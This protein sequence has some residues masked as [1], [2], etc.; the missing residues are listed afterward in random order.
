MGDFYEANKILSMKTLAGETPDICFVTG[1]K[2]AGKTTDFEKL[3]FRWALRGRDPFGNNGKFNWLVRRQKAVKGAEMN[4][5]DALQRWYPEFK[6]T[7]RGFKNWS[8]A[9]VYANGVHVGQIVPFANTEFL[10]TSS[11]ALSDCGYTIFDEF[12]TETNSG[13]LPNEVG[14][15]DAARVVFAKGGLANK[16]AVKKPC[17]LLA[18]NVSKYNPYFVRYGV[19]K[20]IRDNTKFARGDIWV[21][22]QTWNE[23][24]A[25]MVAE[26][27][28]GMGK[29]QLE[30]ATGNRWLLDSDRFIGTPG[31]EKRC[32]V[33]FKFEGE[34]YSVWVCEPGCLFVTNKLDGPKKTMLAVNDDDHESGTYLL[35]R[36]HPTYKTLKSNYELGRVM[37]QS[38]PCRRAFLLA[39]GIIKETVG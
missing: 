12:Q 34:L 36:T 18:N 17:I 23:Q 11:L 16:A 4:W 9:F 21:L 22:E 2:S 31:G 14:L 10:K 33:W 39:T 27:V 28:G 5:S 26:N 24:A 13:Y 37:F 19:D 20:V 6:V 30:Y 15:F 7:V 35:P 8:A 3:M 38:E 1:N 25:R 29:K 32:M